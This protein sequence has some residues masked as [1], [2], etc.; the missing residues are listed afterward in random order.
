MTDLPRISVITPSYNQG[1]FIEQTIRS[2]LDQGYADLE[3]IVMDGGSTDCTLEILRKYEGRLRWISEKDRGQ[4][5]AINKGMA[6]ATG[7]VRAF[8]NSDDCYEP[9]A[10]MKVGRFFA[11]HPQAAWLTGRCRIMDQEGQEIRK[12]IT[13]YKNFWLLTHS[14]KALLV[15]DYVS[16]PATFWRKEVV[17][18]VGAFEEANYYTM[19]YDYSLRVG[20]FTNL[21]VLPQYLANF[22]VHTGS[23]TG[24]AAKAQFDA[25]LN[26]AR[27]YTRSQL[28][29]RLHALHNALI[30]WIYGRLQAGKKDNPQVTAAE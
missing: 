8:L 27:R 3:Y 26:V 21:W 7:D 15:I 16:Q 2:V 1:H 12:L 29:L 19:D 9:G 23:K 4:S 30:V 5:H 17:E 10:L 13:G 14:Y 24:L 11:E 6:L 28:L 25:D 22:R 20:Q 18:R